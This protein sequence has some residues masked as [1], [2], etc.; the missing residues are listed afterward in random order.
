MNSKEKNIIKKYFH[1]PN[2][3]SQEVKEF[4]KLI[5]DSAKK[6]A[7]LLYMD[8]FSEG[9]TINQFDKSKV[10]HKIDLQIR[11]ESQGR[12]YNYF[13]IILKVAAVLIL[14]LVL[15]YFVL[16]NFSSSEYHEISNQDL[17][18][19]LIQ[20]VTS[21]SQR[22]RVILPDSSI[23]WLNVNSKIIFPE[24]FS[25]SVRHVELIGEAYFEVIKESDRPFQIESGEIKTT[26]LGTSFTVLAR[27]KANEIDVAV[28]S[29]KV[30]V[31]KQTDTILLAAHEKATYSR[32]ADKITHSRIDNTLLYNAWAKNRFEVDNMPMRELILILEKIYQVDIEMDRS[33]NHCLITLE[34]QNQSL[35]ILLKMIKD[36]LQIRY[37]VKEDK[38]YISGQI[39]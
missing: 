32:T 20:K 17:K 3:S 7:I 14:S 21:S 31:S 12:N 27:P 25:D 19:S 4:L 30:M 35:E 33:L 13:S 28:V 29:G 36:A 10:K 24:V 2:P 11:N 15:S 18:I 9:D 26:V 6:E 23:A 16:Q 37:E 38:I 1:T 34:Y 39:C 5:Q 8:K 22:S